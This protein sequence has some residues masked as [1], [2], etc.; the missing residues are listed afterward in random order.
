L[1]QTNE[2]IV[3][4]FI[5][6]AVLSLA[7]VGLCAGLCA[8]ADRHQLQRLPSPEGTFVLVVDFIKKPIGSQ[9]VVVSLQ[10]KQGLASEV[11]VFRNIKAFNAAWLGPED[12]GICQSGTVQ[13][14][15]TQVT[16]NAHNGNQDFHFH[17]ACP[18]S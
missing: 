5:C 4:A 7:L 15:K 13:D 11:A 12:I 9:D 3:L 16:I 10:E 8:C 17:Y 1:P 14:Y 2:G 6:K 18:L